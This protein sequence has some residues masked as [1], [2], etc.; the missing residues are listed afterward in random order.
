MGA[1]SFSLLTTDAAALAR[2]LQSA[3]RQVQ[4]PT[5]G[6]VFH[7][8]SQDRVG[9]AREVRQRWGGVPTLVAHGLGVMTEQGEHEGQGAVAGLLAS[10]QTA[11]P[12]W[13]DPDEEDAEDSL[14]E[15]IEQAGGEGTLL[16]FLEQL[17][18]ASRVPKNL[19]RLFPRLSVVGGSGTEGPQGVVDREGEF[20]QGAAVGL[21]IRRN[22]PR[23]ALAPGCRVL[24]GWRTVTEARDG[25]VLR[26]DDEPALEALSKV[27]RSVE[28]RPQVLVL[29]PD[30]ATSE[31]Q[32]QEGGLRGA[33]VRPIRGVDPGR[34]AV[35]LGEAVA[36]GSRL[37]FAVLDGGAARQNLEAALREQARATAGAA[38][39]FGLYVNCA[40]RGTGLYGVPNIDSKLI[41]GRFPGV[42]V[43]GVMSSFEIA[44]SPGPA[45]IH[46]YTGVFALFT[47][48]S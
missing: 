21:L 25:T 12:V 33:R 9:L 35:V 8:G 18:W 19:A 32:P 38:A 47:A 42:P 39:S 41:K 31:E 16:L 1:V 17:P 36:P 3:A 48:P 4:R 6:M 27:A 7:A 44:P 46:F 29:L 26:V 40:G 10:G 13:S 28:G 15:K 23:V 45:T 24:G 43:V 14:G 20:H 11:T 37:A 22:G 34:K 2:P 30:P 5:M